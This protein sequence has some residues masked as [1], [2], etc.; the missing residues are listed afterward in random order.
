MSARGRP[1]DCRQQLERTGGCEAESEKLP[2]YNPDEGGREYVA[3]LLRPPFANAEP[4][5]GAI[6]ENKQQPGYSLATIC[7]CLYISHSN[8]LSSSH[9]AKRSQKK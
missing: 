7:L 2:L 9:E 3:S 5:A 6:Q 1:N 4:E 8:G